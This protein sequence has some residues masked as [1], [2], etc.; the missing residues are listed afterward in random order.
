MT[1]C[2]AKN[3]VICVL[4][5]AVALTLLPVG[6]GAANPA[7][8]DPLE[9]A[10]DVLSVAL[11]VTALASTVWHQDPAGKSEFLKVLAA[12]ELVTFGLKYGLDA[13]RPNGGRQ[14]FPS[15]HTAAAFAGAAF[16]HRR[17]GLRYGVPAYALATLVGV[18]R[19]TSRNHWIP[20]VIA[21]AAIGIGANLLFTSP[22]PGAPVQVAWRTREKGADLVVSWRF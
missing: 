13:P 4:S 12:T 7:S 5:T 17:Y 2:L 16:L 11:P 18:S 1:G 9:A 15:G 8:A 3:T 14:S 19:V 20:D 6:A 10:G 22:Y 21:G